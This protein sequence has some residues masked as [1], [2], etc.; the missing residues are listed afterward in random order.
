MGK[1]KVF[2]TRELPP[3]AM[4]RLRNETELEMNQEDRVLTR[5][6][7][8]EGVKGKDALLCQLTDQVDK[9]VLSANPRLK[10]VANYAVGYNNIDVEAATAMGVPVSNT[11]GVLTETSADLAFAL[12]MAG[13][14]RVVEGDKYLRTG[15]WSGWGPLQFLG[16]DIHGTVLGIIGLGRIGTAM[17][18]RGKGFGMKVK[19]WNRT[20]LSET[21]E[22][23]L[24]LSYLA[25]DELL[26]TA[27]FV[28]L[29]VA[30]TDETHHLIGE[31]E[32]KTM[33]PSAL[34]INTARGAVVDEAALVNALE[35]GEIW[36]AALDVYEKEPQVHPKLLEMD[37]VVLLPHMASASKATRTKMAMIAIDTI[38][39]VWNGTEA[40]Y[41]INSDVYTPKRP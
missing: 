12:L 24:G 39:A 8:L 26:K 31:K 1:P 22:S 2:L 18:K 28:S 40:P 21:E 23:R 36:G 3:Q 10:I 32:L 9:E 7:L 19:Y 25:F 16:M 13:A 14:R 11:P 15:A 29:H 30:Y 41:L 20:R 27:D 35:A 38:L 17:A 4:E 37:N 33:K 6:E 34:L 5:H